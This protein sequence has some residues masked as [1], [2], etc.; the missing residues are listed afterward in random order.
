MAQPQEFEKV[1]DKSDKSVASFDESGTSF[2]KKLQH[3]LHSTPAAVPLIVL[4]LAIVIYV[5]A[6][7]R[8]STP[9][10]RA[11]VD[12]AGA[13]AVAIAAAPAA[14]AVDSSTSGDGAA[15]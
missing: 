2:V 8:W 4:V 6:W 13:V 1:L 12:G 15:D 9:G 7:L 10:A 11:S 3:F 14:D 5:R